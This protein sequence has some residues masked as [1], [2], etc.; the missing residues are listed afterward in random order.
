MT[1]VSNALYDADRLI[2]VVAN[3]LNRDL[4]GLTSFVIRI[5]RLLGKEGVA[6]FQSRQTTGAGLV[7]ALEMDEFTNVATDAFL[8][9]FAHLPIKG[10]VGAQGRTE[11]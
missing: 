11:L 9:R 4:D 3:N 2:V 6:S 10:L 1:Q 7:F 8:G 5:V